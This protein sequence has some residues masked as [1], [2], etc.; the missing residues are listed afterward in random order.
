[1][2]LPVIIFP[3]ICCRPFLCL[4]HHRQDI[5][6]L[7]KRRFL[8]Q[9]SEHFHCGC[10]NPPLLGEGLFLLAQNLFYN[11]TGA[12]HTCTQWKISH[13]FHSFWITYFLKLSIYFFANITKYI[14]RY[15]LLQSFFPSAQSWMS[16][17]IYFPTN[18]RTL[19][20]HLWRQ[21]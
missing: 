19:D 6:P 9:T 15:L 21:Q 13:Y 7:L 10:K 12:K 3:P 5:C 18:W 8:C 14:I 2:I 4:D 11:Y 17:Q 1:M 16:I 20:G